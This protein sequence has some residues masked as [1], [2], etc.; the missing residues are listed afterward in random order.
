MKMLFLINKQQQQKKPKKPLNIQY[1]KNQR[2]GKQHLIYAETKYTYRHT[3][4][5]QNLIHMEGNRGHD[6]MVVGFS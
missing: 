2:H 1:C 5:Q 4:L 3:D 6:H